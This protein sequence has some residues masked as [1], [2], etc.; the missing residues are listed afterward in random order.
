MSS[1]LPS[2]RK[3][4]T[5]RNNLPR[6]ESSYNNEQHQLHVTAK[7][8]TKVQD[9]I[10]KRL[11]TKIGL[12]SMPNQSSMPLPSNAM[13][14][15]TNANRLQLPRETQDGG[16]PRPRPARPVYDAA[17]FNEPDFNADEY[18]RKML[19][20][21]TPAE[22]DDF[23]QALQE[24]KNDTKEMMQK[25]VFRNYREF[26]M[27][28]K[29]IGTLESDM[30]TIRGLLSDLRGIT[31]SLKQ[32][33]E[34]DDEPL[35]AQ[36]RRGAR[37]S[38]VDF[39]QLNKNHLRALWS[40]VE[41]AQKFLPADEGRRI[42]RE[43]GA[44][45]ELNAATWR[46]KNKVHIVLLN[47]HLLV[48]QQKPKPSGSG[49]RLIAD[50]CFPLGDIKV[51]E[52]DDPEMD[53]AL[54][55]RSITSR[56][57]FVYKSNSKDEKKNMLIAFNRELSDLSA[58]QHSL[59]DS[60][61]RLTGSHDVSRDSQIKRI[62]RRLSKNPQSQRL[63]ISGPSGNE[64][65]D[66]SV[67]QE[68]MDALDQ[69]IAHREYKEAVRSIL[70]GRTLV[71]QAAI[72]DLAAELT[73]LRLDQRTESLSHL[74]CDELIDEASR[75]KVVKELVGYLT[76]LS[77]TDL[78]SSTFLSARTKL[79]QKR[80]RWVIFDGDLSLYLSDLSLV[81]FTLLKSTSVMYFSAFSASS[82]SHVIHWSQLRVLEFSNV[83]KNQ[84][85][86]VKEKE[87]GEEM[88]RACLEG[89]GRQVGVL[90]DVGLDLSGVVKDALAGI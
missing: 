35:R 63:S 73:S 62:S 78:A 32:D 29:E 3:K 36:G 24:S 88:V 1:G 80:T 61:K 23:F 5:T 75:S 70:R 17:V 72:N 83:V 22:L 33:D 6:R 65:I 60:A 42:V 4:K 37:N 31:T 38:I 45:V 82:A 30:N 87:G 9:K 48:A 86:K 55:I 81:T 40:Q 7:D 34:L 39:H 49:Q 19:A 50:R 41:G 25:N 84:L 85:W 54:S 10:K 14:N 77:R 21:A 8:K 52:F 15:I 47:D 27:I 64:V 13:R 68:R 66:L 44:W 11:S 28:S 43:S 16:S 69:L 89:I 20:T 58:L 57:K 2:L 90:R 12:P 18:V 56:E 26:I 46:P 71:N 79:L 67:V 59:D 53:T 74:L 51:K 76:A